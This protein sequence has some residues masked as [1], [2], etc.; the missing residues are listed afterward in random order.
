MIGEEYFLRDAEFY[1]VLQPLEV[2]LL[3]GITGVVFLL[4]RYNWKI[5]DKPSSE[6]GA[7]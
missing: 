7:V 4:V 1:T 2:T 5:N 6:P 3:F